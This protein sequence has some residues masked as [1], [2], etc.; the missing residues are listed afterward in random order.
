MKHLVL[1]AK[2]TM[3][4]LGQHDM[5]H[6]MLTCCMEDTANNMTMQTW[7]QL[8]EALGANHKA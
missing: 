2:N 3:Q 7:T 1:T 5:K 6:Q 8:H 4:T